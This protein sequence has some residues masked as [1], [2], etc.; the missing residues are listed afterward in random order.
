MIAPPPSL[1]SAV[2]SL[3]HIITQKEAAIRAALARVDSLMAAGPDTVI[4]VAAAVDLPPKP[5][6]ETVLWQTLIGGG[7]A[8]VAGFGA[9]W[10][11]GV[12]ETR[13]VRT[14]LIGRIR[15][16]LETAIAT[17][18]STVK[19]DESHPIN[20]E[21]MEGLRI[22]WERYDRLSDNLE[23]LGD[24]TFEERVDSGLAFMRMVA[25]KAL[26]DER[27][28][29]ETRREV[30]VKTDKGIYV[31]R[32]IEASIRDQRKALLVVVD[33]MGDLTQG[34]LEQFNA[35][36]PAGARHD[37]RRVPGTEENAGDGEK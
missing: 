18:R 1:A 17:A 30:G 33:G 7:L 27:R 36:W 37:P 19:K 2:D 8:V 10:F 9:Q 14:Q 24:P 5:W 21:T 26:E 15:G 11:R 34:L 3:R 22:E 4:R 32:S 29:R 20:P 16:A 28:F 13:R 23:L 31:D 35:K 12:L 6:Y 25:D